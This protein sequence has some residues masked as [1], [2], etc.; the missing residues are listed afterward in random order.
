MKCKKNKRCSKWI[1]EDYL[2]EILEKRKLLITRLEEARIKGY[3]AFLRYNKLIV[4]V[5]KRSA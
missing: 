5:M 1:D 4:R 2:K 3:R